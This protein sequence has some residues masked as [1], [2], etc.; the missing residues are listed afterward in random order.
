MAD[1]LQLTAAQIHNLAYGGATT[2]SLNPQT[3]PT[4]SANFVPSLLS[5][6][7]FLTQTNQQAEQTLN[8]DALYVLWAGANDYLQGGTG[9]PASRSVA[10]IA[11]AIESLM[12]LGAKRFLIANLPDLGQLPGTRNG[13]ESEALSSL[14]QTH[15][16]QLQQRLISLSQQDADLQVVLLNVERLYQEVLLHPDSFGFTNATD[17]CLNAQNICDNPDRFLFWDSI[18]PTTTAHQ[19]LADTA[20]T[21][22]EANNG[23]DRFYESILP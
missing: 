20:L 12:D 8:P 19:R 7:A 15:N 13:A 4:G 18:H 5:Q 1:R 10:N 23:D 14:T 3:D 11:E 22:L 17:A 9:I 6:V 21:A 16:Q 2:G